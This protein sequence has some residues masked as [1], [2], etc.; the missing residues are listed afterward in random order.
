MH[1]ASNGSERAFRA[2]VRD[3]L[4]NPTVRDALDAVRSS[5]DREPDVRPLYRELGRHGLLAVSW[6]VEYGGRGASHADAAAVIEELVRGGVPDMLHVLSVQIVGLFLLQ[7]GSAEQ[8]A[9]YLPA[10]AAGDRF[11]TVLYTEPEVGS[12][13]AALSTVAV[14]DGDGYR[15][16]GV[17]VYG[18]KSGMSDLALC[19]ARTGPGAT[20]YDN[21]S[22]FLVDLHADGVR[23][24]AI[25]SIA[26]EQFD[27][28]ELDDVRV[29]AD[30][31]LGGEGEGWSLLT[32]C[33]AIE[34]T[35]LD[36]SLKAERWYTAVVA[37]LD[38]GTARGDLIA[39]V[40]RH[41]AAVRQG[42]LLAWDVIRGLDRG[43]LDPAAAAIAKYH[44]SETAQE[45]AVWAA[46]A[47]GHGYAM[48][49]LDDG[50]A[51]VLEAA[52]REAPGLT[53]AAGTSQIML[54]LVASSALDRPDALP[55]P[56]LERIT[57]M[58]RA[59]LSGIPGDSGDVLAALREIDAL[60]FE[61][62][63]AANGFE[64][65]LTCGLAVCIELGRRAL[66]D[67]YTGS[68]LALDALVT[69]NAADPTA[70]AVAAGELLAVPAG[71][72]LVSAGS[73]QAA[74][75]GRRRP[76]ARR[77]TGGWTLCGT[78][79]LD[80]PGPETA[81]CCLPFAADGEVLLAL[82]PAAAWRSRVSV[83]AA[84]HAAVVL[85][86]LTVHDSAVIGGLGTGFPLSDPA[87]LLAR[88]RIRQAA[89]LLGL[90]L[91]ALELAVAYAGSRFQFD[92]P[93][94]ANQAVAFPLAQARIALSAARLGVYRAAWLADAAD[95]DDNG[96]LELVAVEAL[97]STAD[98]AVR[99]IRTAIQVHGARGLS[100]DYPIHAFYRKVRGAASRLGPS[101]ALWA[102]AGARRLATSGR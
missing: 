67:V 52:Y 4:A 3:V 6:P 81:A 99:V 53:L 56:V 74:G 78:V 64:L 31:L 51:A 48:H 72:D 13:L 68:L 86:G 40:G 87:H 33:L 32:R 42:Q 84:G 96:E 29:V 94:L 17:K 39:Q 62:P 21:I 38:P 82:L 92:R 76:Q 69:A 102:E 47:H 15:L 95:V 12:D 70:L 101:T 88:S 73:H 61:A 90:G 65:G 100:L 98:E 45:V 27:R 2:E 35:G 54:E 14:R 37:G 89:Y 41:G 22:L 18:L 59:R 25:A 44:T 79:T 16:R 10:M 7:A 80:E 66:P 11:A 8:K 19:A 34:R 63:A 93:I 75:P 91:G 55:D 85:D 60:A 5:G 30:A 43:A 50:T 49:R 46:D 1:F 77:S 28:I 58:V 36:Y 26:D 83:A 97:A 9:R 71:L 24:S 20:K 23:R 57:Q